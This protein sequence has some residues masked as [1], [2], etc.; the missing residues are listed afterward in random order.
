MD[1]KRRKK[2]KEYFA[3][4]IKNLREITGL[5]IRD[6]CDKIEIDKSSYLRYTDKSNTTIPNSFN[7]DKICS[8]F[9]ISRYDLLNTYIPLDFYKIRPELI[10]F[11]T[12]LE[13][14]I[15]ELIEKKYNV[16]IKDII[17]SFNSLKLIIEFEPVIK[18][19][20][21]EKELEYYIK[22]CAMDL[23]NSKEVEKYC[24]MYYTVNSKYLTAYHDIPPEFKQIYRKKYFKQ[25]LLI[26]YF[27]E[28]T[29]IKPNV[30]VLFRKLKENPTN[31]DVDIFK[32]IKEMT[33]YQFL[34]Y[35]KNYQQKLPD[36]FHID[37]SENEK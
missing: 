36:F 33:L 19:K 8:T 14:Q 7:M 17:Q 23:R 5:S 10:L 6:F 37:I 28:N 3:E 21:E 13:D 15:I 35:T 24:E 20:A 4:N 27:Q 32:T 1:L 9:K 11:S 2:Q 34:K 22:D 25:R 16:E 29:T 12:E 31:D 26:D 18:S 30:K